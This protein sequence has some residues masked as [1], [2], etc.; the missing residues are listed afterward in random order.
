MV[1]LTFPL[2]HGGNK[3]VNVMSILWTICCHNTNWPAKSQENWQAQANG[4]HI[5]INH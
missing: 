3:T 4:S 1:Y 5:K 2:Q